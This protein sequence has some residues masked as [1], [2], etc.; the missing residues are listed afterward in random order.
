MRWM[1]FYVISSR[2]ES[3][4]FAAFLLVRETSLPK[5]V[6]YLTAAGSKLV[7]VAY[8]EQSE[9]PAAVEEALAAQ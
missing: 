9:K 3:E 4:K 6:S 2:N 8:A 7:V 1:V 5:V